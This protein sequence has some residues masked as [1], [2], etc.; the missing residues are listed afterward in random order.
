MAL[1]RL[2]TS[3]WQ[4]GAGQWVDG[5]IDT[6]PSDG[7]VLVDTGALPEGNYLFTVVGRATV[8]AT[9]EVQVRNAANNSTLSSQRRTIAA[10]GN[11]YFPLP[12]KILLSQNQRLRCVQSGN[13]TGDIELSIFYLETM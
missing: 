12:N 10:N 8:Q 4:I 9:Y 5:D 13:L 11:D 1:K 2:P 3:T 7:D 6:N